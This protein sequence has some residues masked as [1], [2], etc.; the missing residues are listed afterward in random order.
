[1]YAISQ[2]LDPRCRFTWWS[3]VGWPEEWIRNAKQQVE[4]E[5]AKY[6]PESE[7]QRLNTSIDV[8]DG[9]YEP[10]TIEEDAL[11]SYLEERQRP[12]VDKLRFWKGREEAAGGLKDGKP[13]PLYAMVRRYLA[14]PASSVPSERCFS[15]AALF[16]PTQRNRLEPQALKES[17][18]IDSWVRFKAGYS[19]EFNDVF[20]EEMKQDKI[21]NNKNK[22]VD[23]ETVERNLEEQ[24]IEER[25][26]EI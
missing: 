8:D 20:E 5:W 18:L 21:K 9:D 15:R 6:M 14:V 19:G 3:Y 23:S 4:D 2:A 25:L 7:Q 16:I 17:V 22:A 26:E 13:Q 11:A 24:L 10:R 12:A 1:M